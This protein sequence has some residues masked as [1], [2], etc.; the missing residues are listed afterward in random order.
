MVPM[1]LFAVEPPK[2]AARFRLVGIIAAADKKGNDASLAVIRDEQS[3]RSMMVR[4]GE[5]LPGSDGILLSAIKRSEV[6]LDAGGQKFVVGY[7]GSEAKEEKQDLVPDFLSAEDMESFY[8]DR[9]SSVGESTETSEFVESIGEESMLGDERT[10]PPVERDLPPPTTSRYFGDA[11]ESAD[12]PVNESTRSASRAEGTVTDFE[13][14]SGEERTV[15]SEA[16]GREFSGTAEGIE[17]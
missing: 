4:R 2:I 13:V 8:Y 16:Q 14:I 11:V 1:R 15:E 5:I 17:D 3:G 10:L 7:G 12:V 6:E 9:R